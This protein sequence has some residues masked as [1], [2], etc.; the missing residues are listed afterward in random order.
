MNLQWNVLTFIEIITFELTAA[1][2]WPNLFNILN[3]HK[4]LQAIVLNSLEINVGF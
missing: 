4:K 1:E 2:L 3:S